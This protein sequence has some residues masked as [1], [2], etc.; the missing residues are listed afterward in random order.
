MPKQPTHKTLAA[1]LRAVGVTNTHNLAKFATH[2]IARETF[3]GT[4]STITSGY[5]LYKSDPDHVPDWGHKR[6]SRIVLRVAL[7]GGSKRYALRD[8][9]ELVRIQATAH[10]GGVE[11]ETCPWKPYDA[12]VPVGTIARALAAK[13]DE[14]AVSGV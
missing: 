4:R 3:Q 11:W 12:W 6:D 5:A 14:D 2:F 9:A 7:L 10:L 1:Q 13:G 8:A